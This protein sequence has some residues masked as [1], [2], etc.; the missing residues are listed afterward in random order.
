MSTPVKCFVYETA[1]P[2]IDRNQSVQPAGQDA[3]PDFH[4]RTGQPDTMVL[5]LGSPEPHIVLHCLQHLVEFAELSESQNYAALHELNV[6][7]ALVPRLVEAELLSVRRLALKLLS[8]MFVHVPSIRSADAASKQVDATFKLA[9]RTFLGADDNFLVEY[10]AGL[11]NC[12]PK[13]IDSLADPRPLFDSIFSSIATTKDPDLLLLNLTLL[14]RLAAEHSPILYGRLEIPFDA[15]LAALRSDFVRVRA[16]T[17]DAL[18]V[19]VQCDTAAYRAHVDTAAVM[20]MCL[21]YIESDNWQSLHGSSIALLGRVL[22]PRCVADRFIAAGDS[23]RRLF[24]FVRHP[25]SEPH[26]LAMLAVLTQLA[27]NPAARP[28]LHANGFTGLLIEHMQRKDCVVTDVTPALA[29]MASN[30]DAAA[31]LID[32]DVVA[33]LFGVLRPPRA[34]RKKKAKRASPAA[35]IGLND[36]IEAAK[37]LVQLF[38]CSAPACEQAIGS[39]DVTNIMASLLAQDARTVPIELKQPLIQILLAVAKQIGPSR[40]KMM[41]PPMA[42]AVLQT[43]FESVMCTVHLV[44]VLNCAIEYVEM[45]PLRELMLHRERN[46]SQLLVDVLSTPGRPMI[47]RKTVI[48]LIRATRMFAELTDMFIEDGVLEW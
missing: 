42:S 41:P 5:L 20:A 21:E 46:F 28:E 26:R 36:Q 44:D 29:Y 19:I 14:V 10:A 12:L 18:L 1:Q 17:L 48:D 15:I 37:C 6:F 7:D 16:A 34:E 38:A 13:H 22:R 45:E 33:W 47:A 8:Q 27:A 35:E 25:N 11:L 23:L 9:M 43:L 4:F 31:M 30:A 40:D 3:A 24:A 39:D 2:R 32:Q